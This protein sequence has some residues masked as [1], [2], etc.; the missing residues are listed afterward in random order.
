MQ[1]F[2]I[3]AVF[4]SQANLSEVIEDSVFAEW[5]AKASSLFDFV[6][7]LSVVCILHD[8]V[9]VQAFVFEYVFKLDD[10]WMVKNF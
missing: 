6:S 9:E 7:Q 2:T 8:H 4:Q 10:V 1:D 3:V 5:L